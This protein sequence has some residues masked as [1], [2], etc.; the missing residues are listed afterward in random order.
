M[1][2]VKEINLRDTVL[3]TFQGQMVIVPNKEVF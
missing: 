1:G 3:Q 2:K